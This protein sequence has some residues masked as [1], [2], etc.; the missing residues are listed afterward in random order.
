M[1]TAREIAAQENAR[2]ERAR[3]ATADWRAANAD[4][5]AMREVDRLLVESYLRTCP[6]QHLPRVV[7]D[8]VTALVDAG[9]DKRKAE[10]LIGLRLRSLRDGRLSYSLARRE[11]A[12][13]AALY[14]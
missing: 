4:R 10:R 3:Q 14:R 8:V 12:E 1:S 5:P 2:R 11:V 6:V 9:Y 7:G 13:N